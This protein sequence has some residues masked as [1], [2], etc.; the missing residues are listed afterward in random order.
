MRSG[1]WEIDRFDLSKKIGISLIDIFQELVPCSE[2]QTVWLLFQVMGGDQNPSKQKIICMQFMFSNSRRVYM[3]WY[4][5]LVCNAHEG[6]EGAESIAYMRWYAIV[7]HLF[8]KCASP[9]FR[10]GELLADGTELQAEFFDGVMSQLLRVKTE[11]D[12]FLLC[13]EG[14]YF[15]F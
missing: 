13:E 11:I 6:Y 14:R 4:I 12:L 15:S 9:G 7:L 8:G 2:Y 1:S 10:F 5:R 3:K